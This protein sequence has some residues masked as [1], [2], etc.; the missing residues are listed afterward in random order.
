MPRDEPMFQEAR[1]GGMPLQKLG[2]TIEGTALEP[3]LVEFMG[4]L[5]QAG[6]NRLKPAFYLSTE[7]GVN[8]GTVAIGIPF[9]LAR[10]DL[11]ELHEE[12]VGVIEGSDRKD[13][14]RYLRHEMG[15]VVN[16]AYHLYESEE[17][18]RLFGSFTQPYVEDYRPKPFSTRYVR[19]LPGW[20]A[21]KHPDEDWSETFAVWMTPGFDWR[22]E[23]EDWPTALE[24]LR[25]C[26]RTMT[27]LKDRD[28]I[29]LRTDRDEDV[30]EM[31]VSVDEYYKQLES[32][33]PELPKGIDGALRTVFD[34]AT[35]TDIPKDAPL[36]A[37]SALI[38]R[39]ER[40]LLG[41]IYL[42]TG[43]F[44]ETTRTLLRHMSRRADELRLIY[45]ESRESATLVALT[46]LATALAM[47]HV[48]TGRYQ[49]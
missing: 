47:N 42:W 20:Y 37:A 34:L 16:Y 39:N 3:I 21:Q 29:E 4:E 33:H 28:P 1:L 44:P 43:H 12:R 45:V 46:T 38:R 2:L 49:P 35:D 48:Y 26:D 32:A 7:W 10:P 36:K 15:H 24:K 9:Y 25:F 17:W 13:I 11:V 8:Q 31:T 23:Y 19:H 41:A 22:S 14:L 27:L 40:S 30:A 18:V 6:L 5:A